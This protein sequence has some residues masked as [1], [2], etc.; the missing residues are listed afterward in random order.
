MELLLERTVGSL[1]GGE[2]ARLQDLRQV[3][4]ELVDGILQRIL[5]RRGAV[6]MMM[7]VG[8]RGGELLQ[9]LTDGGVVLLSRGEIARGESLTELAEG[10][11]ERVR[12][13]LRVGRG[14]GR[15]NRRLKGLE[16]GLR[17]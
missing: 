16:I 15:L 6:R 2:I 4:E 1:R 5:R 14:G 13:S 17:L 3:G 8:A 10:I 7:K 11:G 9:V 12:G